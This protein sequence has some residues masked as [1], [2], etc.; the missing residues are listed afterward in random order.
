QVLVDERPLLEAPGHRLP[1]RSAGPT[2][3]DDQLLGRLVGVAGSAFGLAPRRHRVATTR[4]LALAATERVIDRV[5]GHAAGLRP[6]ALPTVAAR[7]ADR[8][9]LGL[10]V[11]DLADCRPGADGQPPRLASWVPQGGEVDVLGDGVD[12]CTGAARQ[13]ASCVRP[14]LVV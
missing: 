3:A 1:P 2:P 4:G 6:L 8:D 14:E 5:H 7:L 9:E 12:E 13:R 10:G 11:P